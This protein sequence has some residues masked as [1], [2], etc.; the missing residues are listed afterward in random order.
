ML[1]FVDDY[2]T[3]PI[4][5]VVAFPAGGGG[6]VHARIVAKYLQK[7]TGKNFTVINKPGG[8][9]LIGHSYIA[10]LARP[11]GYTV[12]M[13]GNTFINDTLL[14]AEGKWSLQ[15]VRPI[16]AINSE[17]IAWVVSTEGR[18]KSMSLKEIAALARQ[19]PGSV[20]VAA[21]IDSKEPAGD[22]D[23]LLAQVERATDAR[24]NPV[25]YQGG[26][27]GVL[28]VMGGHLDIA[29][30]YAAEYRALAA[31]G[32]IRLLGVASQ[33]RPN[34]STA[35]ATFNEQLG[36]RD[37]VWDTLRFA[38]VPAATPTDR[39]RWLEAAF[40]LALSD[41]EIEREFEQLGA[42]SARAFDSPQKLEAEVARRYRQAST[43][44]AAI[45]A[46]R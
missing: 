22:P 21:T 20:S 46:S 2:P 26:G 33:E 9:G 15:D 25:A 38:I 34:G 14:R 43:L 24:F 16:A 6:D 12:G 31:S 35:V 4:E 8:V 45:R 36:V 28:D 10:R 42:Q 11:D 1:P 29:F 18:F 40:Q 23:F 5:L 19:Q 37:I 3:R 41:P 17:P 27:R 7:H 39:V 44:A 30:S 13:V 32:R